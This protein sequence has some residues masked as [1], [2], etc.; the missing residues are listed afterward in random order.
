MKLACVFVFMFYESAFAQIQV[1]INNETFYRLEVGEEKF[2]SLKPSQEIKKVWI[3]DR[4]ILKADYKQNK[5]F[6]KALKNGESFIRLNE[7]LIKIVST[8]A[9][10]RHILTYRDQFKNKFVGLNFEYCDY[11]ICAVGE[12]YRLQDYI[13]LTKLAQ[14]LHL[15]FKL[16]M[17]IHDAL[18]IQIKG[19]VAA[20]FREN[21]LTPQKI[22]FSSVWKVYCSSENVTENFRR[23]ARSL[24]LEVKSLKQLNIIEDN[25]SVSVKIV[26]LQKNFMRKIGLQWPDQYR[27]QVLDQVIGKVEPF[28]V[29]LSA[30]EA[31]GEARILASPNLL[32]RSGKE[33]QFFAGGEY[34]IK[35]ISLR[36]QHIVW[37]KYGVGLKLLPHLD[38]L[39]QLNLRL[40]TEISSIDRSLTADDM[41]AFA[42]NR[43]SSYFDL[44]DNKTITL[45]GLI[46]NESSRHAEGLPFLK[47]IP[48]LGALFSSRN[49]SENK[50]ELVIFVTP[51]LLKVESEVGVD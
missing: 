30:A 13:K 10:S 9:G 14:E 48:I 22:S 5:I 41:P 34:P 11:G 49:F 33:A 15:N 2:I 1:K 4:A 50:T 25:V 16:K 44:V 39:G 24:A 6:I 3:E 32:S 17:K 43:V 38:P 7:K 40:E 26:E 28:E 29:A 35:V 18:A 47:N 51:R 36:S 46:K 8:E 45:S 23:L 31:N 37:K 21:G 19:Y 12:L 42:F 20:Q 27:A